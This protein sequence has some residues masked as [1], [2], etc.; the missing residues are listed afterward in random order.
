VK[1]SVAGPAV[2]VCRDCCCG[3]IHKHPSADHDAQLDA[4]RDG[5]AGF[6]RVVVSQCLLA[7]ER[8]NVV[9]VSP[10]PEQR[11]AGVKPV[12]LARIL[13]PRETQA[14][15]DWVK[16]GGPGVVEAPLLIRAK[17]GEKPDLLDVDPC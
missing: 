7:C 5:V 1:S 8:S 3:T 17:I 9:V 6:G 12:W 4:L 13:F 2:T 10:A 16:A 11:A 15:I 14:V